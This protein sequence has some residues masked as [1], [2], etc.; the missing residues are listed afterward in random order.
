[1]LDLYIVIFYL[2]FCTT[3]INWFFLEKKILFLIYTFLPNEFFYTKKICSF[4]LVYFTQNV[5]VS[6]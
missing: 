5:D 6:K 4:V 3:L 1:M 2:E